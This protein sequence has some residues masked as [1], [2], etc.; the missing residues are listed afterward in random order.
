MDQ[1]NVLDT[2]QS[3]LLTLRGYQREAVSDITRIFGTDSRGPDA[4]RATLVMPC[5]TGKT[6]VALEIMSSHHGPVVVFVPTVAL[7]EQMAT[8]IA[9]R[10]ICRPVVAVCDDP[11]MT[12]RVMDATPTTTDAA[13]LALWLTAPPGGGGSGPLPPPVVI[14][15]YAS[16]QVV[17]EACRRARATGWGGFDLMVADEAHRTTVN[18]ARWNVVCDDMYIPARHRLYCT[19]TP[20]IVEVEGSGATPLGVMDQDVYGETVEPL[21]WGEAIRC[22]YLSDYQVAVIAVPHSAVQRY[23]DA[24]MA[25]ESSAASQIAVLRYAASR[26]MSTGEDMSLLTFCNT[27]SASRQW[28]DSF[29]RVATGMGFDDSH[30]WSAALDG[31]QPCAVRS[32]I[33]AALTDTAHTPPNLRVVANCKVLAEG[34]DIPALDGVCFAQPRSSTI[35]IVQA[36]GRA[37]RPHPGPARHRAV[38]ILPVVICEPLVDVADGGAPEEVRNSP[39]Y[40]AWQVI[41]AMASVDHT[42]SVEVARTVADAATLDAAETSAATG[43]ATEMGTDRAG[44]G[45]AKISVDTGLLDVSKALQAHIRFKLHLFER[46]S[47]QVQLAQFVSHWSAHWAAHKRVPKPG[48]VSS[49]GYLLGDRTAYYRAKYFAPGSTGFEC[50]SELPGWGQ[51]TPPV[52]R[53]TIAEK[54]EIIDRYRRSVAES[55]DGAWCIPAGRRTLDGLPVGRWVRALHAHPEMLSPDQRR[56]VALAGG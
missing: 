36:V 6:L 7:V 55:E 27:V 51:L 26:H 15:T 28:A 32:R 56:A 24:G 12:D 39:F 35:S 54:V 34:V 49:E 8:M 52:H 20:K 17:V 41:T 38:V 19:A 43:A 9:A 11:T 21:S 33:V 45:E 40:T 5:G 42:L 18:A 10:R 14:S 53:R 44:T 30:V 31:T 25:D 46:V 4:G 23:L 2:E 1:K 13:T 48:W 16:A 3:G 22:G 50:L 37:L 47:E 29:A